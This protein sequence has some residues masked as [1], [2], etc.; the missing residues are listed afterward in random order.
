MQVQRK[1]ISVF[2]HILDILL[3]ISTVFLAILMILMVVDII[4]RTFFS[5]PIMGTIEISGYCLVYMTFL[6]SAWLLRDEGHVIVDL[7]LNRVN[8]STQRILNIIASI[9]GI[10]MCF[11]LAW[12]SAKATI[13]AYTT[14]YKTVSELE[15]PMFPM[16]AAIPIGI[17]MLAIQFVRRT[18]GF[19]KGKSIPKQY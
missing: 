8:K 17:F 5:L 13:Y 7:V 4:A 11:I 6:G 9:L 1:I 15:I 14:D 18:Y 2:D 10:V 12:F 19:W 3:Y 16:L